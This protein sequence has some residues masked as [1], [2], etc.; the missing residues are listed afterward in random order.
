MVPAA[1]AAAVS[2]LAAASG[3]SCSPATIHGAVTPIRTSPCHAATSAVGGG[4]ARAAPTAAAEQATS[5]SFSACAVYAT[6]FAACPLTAYGW[7]ASARGTHQHC[8]A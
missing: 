1:L 2:F 4:G 3:A 6:S 8:P 5:H 7:N